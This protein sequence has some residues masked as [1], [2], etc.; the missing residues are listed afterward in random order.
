MLYQAGWHAAKQQIALE[1]NHRI[2]GFIGGLLSG[3]LATAAGFL[4]WIACFTPEFDPSIAQANNSAQ[5]DKASHT[6]QTTVNPVPSFELEQNQ[7]LAVRNSNSPAVATTLSDQSGPLLTLWQ[8]LTQPPSSTRPLV[9]TPITH[10]S[11]IQAGDSRSN[12][13][14]SFDET[15]SPSITSPSGTLGPIRFDWQPSKSSSHHSI[16]LPALRPFG[17]QPSFQS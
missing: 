1:Q 4:I 10:R 13:T 14:V 3:G 8:S 9:S 2:R 5:N 6:T 7:S 15:G 16:E 11:V 12:H 17:N